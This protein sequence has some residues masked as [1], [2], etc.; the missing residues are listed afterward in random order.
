MRF[1]YGNL[2]V[3]DNV[4]WMILLDRKIA[5]AL[6]DRNLD[7]GRNR[8]PDGDFPARSGRIALVTP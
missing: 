6:T 5:Y 4:A 7:S 8:R 3:A 2:V 1:H